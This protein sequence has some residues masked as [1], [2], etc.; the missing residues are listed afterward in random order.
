MKYIS[1]MAFFC[2][3]ALCISGIASAQNADRITKDEAYALVKRIIAYAKAN[4]EEKAKVACNTPE[5]FVKGDGYIFA[6]D[7][8]GN[9]VCHRESKLRGKN[10]FGMQDLDGVLMIQKMLNQCNNPPHHGWQKYKWPNQ[11]TNVVEV[12]ESYAEKFGNICWASGF[13][14]GL[15]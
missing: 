7:P 6:Y 14:V 13:Y 3:T 4:G 8:L 5:F 9:N 10:L 11:V 2:V 12:K 15:K 1:K